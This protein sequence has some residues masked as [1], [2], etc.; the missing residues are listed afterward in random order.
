MEFNPTL[1]ESQF[2]LTLPPSTIVTHWDLDGPDVPLPQAKEQA[3]FSLAVPTNPP[4][5]YQLARTVR[6]DGPVPAFTFVYKKG[7]HYVL[8]TEYKDLGIRLAAA[9]IGVPVVAGKH[10]GKLVPGPLS[11]SYTYREAGVV[12]QVFANLP[13][14]EVVKIAGRI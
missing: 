11:S 6:V 13:F 7:I 10:Q 12:T 5:G 8:Y 14:E 1:D 2:D 4:E 3:N 9:E